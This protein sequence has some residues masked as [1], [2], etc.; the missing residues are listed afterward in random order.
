MIGKTGSYIVKEAISAK[1]LYQILLYNSAPL[2]PDPLPH[3]GKGEAVLIKQ[4]LDNQR[5]KLNRIPLPSL[6]GEGSGVG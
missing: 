1:F 6:F 5:L 2:P 3:Q 4:K